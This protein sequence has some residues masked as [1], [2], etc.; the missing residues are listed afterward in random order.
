M[1]EYKLLI[2]E[3]TTMSLSDLASIG[4]FI[5]GLAV[6]VTLI[7]LLLQMR[8]TN[9]NQRALMQQGRSARTADLLMRL[10]GPYMS[11]I[12]VRAE[13]GDQ[14]LTSAEVH[15][16]IRMLGSFFSNYE[17][18]F[19]Q[20]RAGTLDS[21]SWN[22]DEAALRAVLSIPAARLSWSIL[23]VYW[24]G[25]YG[26]YVDNILRETKVGQA[27]DYAATWKTLLS[28]T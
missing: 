22:S 16:Y 1:I 8:Q 15:S 23:R 7:F 11:E 28:E 14:T 5:S 18:S 6:T 12:V 24:I 13:R 26:E 3:R 25:G 9:K 27:L 2:R 10:T 4:S 20:F 17:D 19:L 21:A